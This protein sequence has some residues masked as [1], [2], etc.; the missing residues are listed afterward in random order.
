MEPDAPRRRDPLLQRCFVLP[1]LEQLRTWSRQARAGERRLPLIGLN[2]P[3]GAG[4]TSLGRELEA[5]AP[6]FGLRLLVASIDDVYLG[7]PERGER[8]AGN[9]FAVSRVP[10]GSHDLPLLL[11]ALS[12]WREGG[13]LRLPRF[14]KT[15]AGGQGD[16]SGWR[17]QA[18]DA[19]VLEGWLMGCHPLPESRL[20]TLLQAAEPG[21][22]EPKTPA[23][24]PDHPL[25]SGLGAPVLRPEEWRWLPRWN[26]ELE[27]YQ[28]LWQACDGVW[29]LRPLHWGLPRRWRFQAEARQRRRGGGWLQPQELERLVRASLCSLPPALYQDPLCHDLLTAHGTVS[30]TL[31]HT[32]DRDPGAAQAITPCFPGSPANVS[33]SMSKDVGAPGTDPLK[34]QHAGSG[35]TGEPAS[36][37]IFPGPVVDPSGSKTS[38]AELSFSL[39]DQH[40]E[41][42]LR[43]PRAV[44]G[45][46]I[47]AVAWLDGRRRCFAVRLQDSLSPSSSATG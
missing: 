23:L 6:Q 33:E 40:I 24:G 19:L 45:P 27:R 14:D 1:L 32:G 21:R 44:N 31:T 38:P 17:E 20:N 2:G 26:L 39:Q 13:V 10:P 3:V 25:W 46:L 36:T 30:W 11:E 7:W 47:Q 9:P 35:V 5:L 42:S 37:G 15:L 8:L 28:Q 29:L 41:A 43:P 22:D 4:K 34:G 12:G 18:C 16:R